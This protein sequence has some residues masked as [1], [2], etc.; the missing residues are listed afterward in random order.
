M[1]E[2]GVRGPALRALTATAGALALLPCATPVRAQPAAVEEVVVT[3]RKREERLLETP[4]A[5]SAV[6]AKDIESLGLANLND[7]TKATPG[8][9]I[10]NYGTQRND[11]ATQVLTIRGM[12]PSINTI[13]AASV[14]IN[15]APVTGGFVPGV[16]DLERAEVIKGPQSAYFGRSSFAGAVNLVT[17]RPG[18][19]FSGSVSGPLD[20]RACGAWTWWS[21]A[22]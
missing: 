12:P 18:D 16:A 19:S 2:H 3:A 5:V 15:G 6:T 4:V 20:G 13:P 7:I 14:F 17:K 21:F 10:S 22:C 1:S 11:R 9:F 8:F